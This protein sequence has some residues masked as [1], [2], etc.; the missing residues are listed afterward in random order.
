[1][2]DRPTIIVTGVQGMLGQ[3]VKDAFVNHPLSSKYRMVTYGRQV[4]IASR[5][6]LLKMWDLSNEY[7]TKWWVINCAGKREGSDADLIRS[8]ALGPHLLAGFVKERG[9]RLIHVSSDCVLDVVGPHAIYEHASM[10]ARSKAMGEPK[11]AIVYRTSFIG[12][13]HG[14]LRW[15]LDLPKNAAVDGYHLATWCG[16]TVEEVAAKLFTPIQTEEDGFDYHDGV[17]NMAAQETSKFA[18]LQL[19]RQKYNRMDIGVRTET[20]TRIPRLL[21]PIDVKLRSVAEVWG[22]K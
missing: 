21:L 1:M 5:Y 22:L 10:Y 9:G 19:I 8:N 18:L 12:E 15:F 14:L 13:R 2:G 7:G 16:S 6:D 20:V 4:S 11:N 17:Y 3:A